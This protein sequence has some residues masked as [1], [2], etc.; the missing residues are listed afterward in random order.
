MSTTLFLTRWTA[1]RESAQSQEVEVSTESPTANEQVVHNHVWNPAKSL[2]KESRNEKAKCTTIFCQLE[3]CPIRDQGACMLTPALGWTRCPYGKVRTETGP[4]KRAK[5]FYKWIEE[6]K[7]AHPGVGKLAYPTKKM[8]FVGEYVYLPY[9]HMTMCEQVPFLSHASLTNGNCLIPVTE[10]TLENVIILIDFKP[11]NW[12]GHEIES[13]QKEEVPHY[14][15]PDVCHELM[16][17]IKWPTGKISCPHCGAKG[18]RIGQVKTR[19]L[20]RCKDCR[21]QISVK[22]DTIFEDSPLPLQKWFV[23]IWC[24]ANC[25]NGIS[26]HEL[27]RAIGVRQATAWFMLGRIRKAMEA[28]NF[29]KQDGDHEADTT[30]IG[31]K[32]ANMHKGVREKKITGRGAANKTAVHGVLKRTD[33]ENHSTVR[34]S[35]IT[36]ESAEKLMADVRR[37]VKRGCRIFTDEAAAYGDLA[38]THIHRA[39]DHS[40]CYAIGQIHVNGMENFWSLLKRTLGGTYVSIAPFH[41]YRYVVEQTWRYNNRQNDDGTRFQRALGCVVGKK[42]TYRLLTNQGDAGFMGIV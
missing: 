31:G 1:H 5:S 27:G 29:T 2:F 15:D 40:K 25:K 23:A 33:G 26:S 24:V 34:T 4:T 16:L 6:R 21:K 20:I 32:A 13:Y 14:S 19:R 28:G 3:S 17:S 37:H 9:S 7:D 11:R 38:L 39:I 8:D 36:S 42:L 12:G 30:Y 35:V 10:W 18:D 22:V 41:L